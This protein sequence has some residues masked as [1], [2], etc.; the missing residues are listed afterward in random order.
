[1]KLPEPRPRPR[2]PASRRAV[3][4]C[5]DAAAVCAA[6][7]ALPRGRRRRGRARSRRRR[8]SL[9]RRQRSVVADPARRRRHDLPRQR[10]RPRSEG[11]A[12]GAVGDARGRALQPPRS[13]ARARPAGADGSQYPDE[14]PSGN[15]SRRQRVQH[16]RGD[17][18]HRSRERSRDH[19]RALR[20]VSVRDRRHRQHHR[21]G[22][23]DRGACG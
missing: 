1:M 2:R 3:H 17:S 18:G 8:R 16:H 20:Y 21:I 15:Q 11:A 9:R 19:G 22:G 23:D 10:R 12:A 4:W 6:R 14:V 13:T 5:H 7:S